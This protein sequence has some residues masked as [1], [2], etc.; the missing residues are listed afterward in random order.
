MHKGPV[1]GQRP[2][3]FIAKTLLGIGTVLSSIVVL[4]IGIGFLF[5]G[6]HGALVEQFGASANWIL[7]GACVAVGGG[8]PLSIYLK[9]RAV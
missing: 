6:A 2:R 8:V 4:A 9:L 7:G 3:N 1:L 5:A